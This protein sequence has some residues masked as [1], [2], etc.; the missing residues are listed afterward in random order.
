MPKDRSV[1]WLQTRNGVFYAHW[2]NP[3]K[4]RIQR[5]SLGTRDPS[6]AKARFAAFLAEGVDKLAAGEHDLTCGEALDQYYDEHLRLK[7]VAHERG[8]MAIQNLK[9]FFAQ[10]RVKDIDIPLCRDYAG[11]RRMGLI[12]GRRGRSEI[13]LAGSDSTIRRELAVLAAACQHAMKWKRIQRNDLPYIELPPE[14][15]PRERWL[16]VDELA[17]LRDAAEAKAATGIASF[18]RVRH[19][20]E[21]AYYTAS[22]RAAVETL[23]WFQVDLERG[24]IALAK[25]EERKTKKRRPVVPIDP[26]LMP[27]LRR[28]HETKTT[29]YVLGVGTPLHREFMAVAEAA[30]LED[31]TPHTLRHSR[32]THLLQAGVDPW[33]V[34]GLL[35]DSLAT[36][37]KVYGH[38]CPD[39]LREAMTTAGSL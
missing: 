36:V 31:V 25:A 15:P 20:I 29:G 28:L 2:S 30:G 13:V 23:T 5:L 10:L 1:P 27:L 34:A 4:G 21:I 35:G 7:A 8:R 39:H 32:A 11:R 3:E 18:V 22:R 16:T 38:H 37:V 26:Q 12:G 19:F 6:T 33:K 9:A 17:K 24:R 14:G